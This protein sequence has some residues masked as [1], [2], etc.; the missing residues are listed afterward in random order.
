M[1]GTGVG[2]LASALEA[3][4]EASRGQDRLEAVKWLG[5]AAMVADHAGALLFPELVALRIVGRIALPAFLLVLVLRLDPR[6]CERLRLRLL[7]WALLAQGPFVAAFGA[8]QLNVF[9]SLAAGVLLAA[10]LARAR[11]LAV[12]LGCCLAAL[13]EYP[14]AAVCIP[15]L[16]WARGSA[17]FPALLAAAAAFANMITVGGEDGLVAAGVAAA[18]AV[19][20]LAAWRLGS[21]PWRLPGWAFY[22]FYPAHLVALAAL[23]PFAA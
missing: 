23:R 18:C 17:A 9:A 13:S 11:F 15:L 19:A 2:G 7:L 1:P 3:Q 20:V 6:D 22:A 10:G 5:V 8:W 21:V 16:Y 12:L 4:G 14:G